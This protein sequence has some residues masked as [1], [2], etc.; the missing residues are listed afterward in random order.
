MTKAERQNW[1]INIENTASFIAS[2]IGKEV[3]D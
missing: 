2:K 3:V 1:I